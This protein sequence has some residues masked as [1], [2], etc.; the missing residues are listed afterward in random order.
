MRG[1]RL[2]TLRMTA[3]A[4]LSLGYPWLE[5][6]ALPSSSPTLDRLTLGPQR[7]LQR[8]N[9]CLSRTKR[10]RTGRRKVALPAAPPSVSR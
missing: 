10:P 1:A 9:K 8:S 5:M 7:S 6:R 2:A 4:P 3:Q